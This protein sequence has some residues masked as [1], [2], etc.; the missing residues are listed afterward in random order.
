MIYACPS[1]TEGRCGRKHN[2][3]N[4]SP[5]STFIDGTTQKM[6]VQRN[7]KARSCNQCYSG[8][9]MNITYSQLTMQR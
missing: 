5:F 4:G 6:Y 2:K 1:E 9:A 8:K 7:I 3:F